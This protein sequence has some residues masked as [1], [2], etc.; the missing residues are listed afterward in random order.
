MAADRFRVIIVG[1]SVAGLTLAH[2]LASARIDFVLLEGRDNI[3]PK[4][5]ATIVM[6][7]NGTRVLD[8]LGLYQSMDDI[9]TEVIVHVT[10][11]SDGSLIG[12][13]GW[14]AIVKD[15]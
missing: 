9:M 2:S 4:L 5:G 3:S 12:R 13:N 1:G 7:P 10:R 14:P 8:Q 6:M 15:R 11:R